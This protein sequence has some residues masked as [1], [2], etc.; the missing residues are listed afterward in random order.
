[1]LA[2]GGYRE[3]IL[4]DV[5]GGTRIGELLEGHRAS[6]TSVAFSP[7]GTM[8]ASGGW[9]EK[10]ILWDVPGRRQIVELPEGHAHIVP[11]VAF[12]PDGT[13]LASAGYDGKVI[14]GMWGPNRASGSRLKAMAAGSRAWPSTPTA[15]R[16]PSAGYDSGNDHP[17]GR[18][19][20]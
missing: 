15:R 1:M 20:P 3:I 10:V 12:S 2:L 6:V 7:D 14:L 17:V 8:L 13:L 19:Q 16:S 5:A 18:G 9:D 11:S 4:W